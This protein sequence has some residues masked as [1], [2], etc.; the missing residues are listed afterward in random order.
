MQHSRFRG[1]LLNNSLS[2][3]VA[4]RRRGDSTTTTID[5]PLDCGRPVNYTYYDNLVG[6]LNRHKH[7]NVPEP[8]IELIFGKLKRGGKTNEL[9]VDALEKRLRKA[10]REVS[11]LS[12]ITAKIINI[13]FYLCLLYRQQVSKI[14]LKA[15]KKYSTDVDSKTKPKSIII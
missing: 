4:P 11:I 9:D 1:T 8:Q 3:I 6:V 12:D 13:F 15:I 5:E 2:N 7:P 14:E 10:K